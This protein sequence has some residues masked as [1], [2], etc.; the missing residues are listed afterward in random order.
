MHCKIELA[1]RLVI[2]SPGGGGL[3]V[4]DHANNAKYGVAANVQAG[5]SL[6]REKMRGGK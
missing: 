6:S 1:D 5:D 2:Q 3:P 4:V